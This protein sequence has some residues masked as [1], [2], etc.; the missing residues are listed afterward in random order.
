MQAMVVYE[1]MFGN[2]EQVAKAVADGLAPYAEVSVVN[3]DDVKGAVDT[4]LLV[5]GGPTHMHGLS[6]PSSRTEA[7]RQAVDEV[8]SRTGLRDWLGT[9]GRATGD[10]RVA[11]F[12]T[13]IGKPRWLTGSAAIGA[14]R[15]LR[16]LGFVPFVRPESFI[17]DTDK[18]QT[19]LRDGEL[20]RARDWGAALGKRLSNATVG[21]G[22]R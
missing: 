15:K 9:L 7:T 20:E 14:E 11:T 13:R 2:T 22:N 10:G 12:D 8:R 1:S 5:V 6:R 19:V 21:E 18:Q 16:R 4:D 3:V 17:V